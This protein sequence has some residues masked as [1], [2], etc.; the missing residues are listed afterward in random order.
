VWQV[1]G[2]SSPRE[3][4]MVALASEWEGRRGLVSRRLP[5]FRLL[6]RRGAE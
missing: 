5:P 6:A 1:H 2:L 4:A 3:T